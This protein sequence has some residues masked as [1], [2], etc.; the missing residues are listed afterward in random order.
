MFAVAAWRFTMLPM[1]LALRVTAA[2]ALATASLAGSCAAMSLTTA[3][4]C[5]SDGS[6]SADAITAATAS[7]PPASQA[8]ARA[9]GHLEGAAGGAESV[10]RV[11]AQPE[12]CSALGQQRAAQIVEAQP[13]D[14]GHEPC[15]AL[16][17]VSAPVQAQP[18][19]SEPGARVEGLERQLVEPQR[20]SRPGR[21]CGR[22]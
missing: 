4:R 1:V 11:R 22:G 18:E 7:V 19:D 13:V 16:G 3:H 14:L 8:A 20:A 9:A 10:S 21:L 17:D 5:R 2:R 15:L 12:P 6:R